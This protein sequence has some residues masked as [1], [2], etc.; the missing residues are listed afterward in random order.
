MTVF[1]PVSEVFTPVT[2]V[3]IMTRSK[4]LA[5]SEL[6]CCTVAVLTHRA[7]FVDEDF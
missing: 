1:I 6:K 5:A 7:D 4:K 2:G 3:C